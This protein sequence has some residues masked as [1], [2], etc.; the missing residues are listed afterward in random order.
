MS[1]IS[2]T[3]TA[4]PA[5][6]VDGIKKVTNAADDMAGSVKRSNQEAAQGGTSAIGQVLSVSQQAQ[7]SVGQTI[8]AVGDLSG[9]VR[10]LGHD[11]SAISGALGESVPVIGKIGSALAAVM[12][13]PV[14]LISAAI[15]AAGAAIQKIIADAEARVAR[16]RA[17]VDARSS[18]AYDQLVEGRREYQAALDTLAR[19]RELNALAKQSPLQ[20]DELAAFRSLAGQ[21]GI[22]EKDVTASG[23]NP[24]RLRE[25]EQRLAS[26]RAANAESD[27][28]QY[29]ASFKKQL[30]AAIESSDLS[31]GFKRS[32]SGMKLSE[33]IQYLQD[34]SRSGIGMNAADIRAFSDLYKMTAQY[35]EA[36]A[37]YRRDPLLGRD[38]AALDSAAVDAVKSGVA[39]RVQTAEDRKRMRE[40]INAA[41]DQE[42]A[43]MQSAAKRAQDETDRRERAAE[44]IMSGLQRE[45]A[46]QQLITD[47]KRREAYLLQQRL[48]M[49]SALGRALTE[50]ELSGMETL[51]G[52]LYDLR[53]PA[54]AAAENGG[55]QSGTRSA[56]RPNARRA[57]AETAH[58]DA[59]QR[60]GARVASPISTR[61]S[62]T[63]SRQLDVQREI[64]AAVRVLVPSGITN[65]ARMYFS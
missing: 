8:S 53:N 28:R 26:D 34:A 54:Q 20:A 48:A 51:A 37:A 18:A 41:A 40:K 55:V 50:D 32:L 2:I 6:A 5:Q 59:L 19:V 39:D 10:K 4:D 33:Q 38:Q 45:L 64:Y 43:A 42:A 27:M 13:G 65:Q 60:I 62:D 22:R 9:S 7:S 63:L 46:I 15:A 24:Y 21:I 17:S 44:S 58:L 57:T 23:I 30:A 61:D 49:E 14:G 1:D 11:A 35:T 3:I 52:A 29:T 47:G 36:R 31:D 56:P 16:L 25:A 12:T